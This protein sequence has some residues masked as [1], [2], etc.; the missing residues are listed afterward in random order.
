MK[1]A[2]FITC[3]C[4]ISLFQSPVFAKAPLTLGGFTLGRDIY[5]YKSSLN[6][7]SCREKR[8]QEYVGE[9]EI[10]P[11]PG[12]K[13]GLITYGLCDKVEK[14]IKIKLKIDNPSKKF[15]KKLL[16]K[17]ESTFGSP[18]EYKGDP[19]QTFIAWKWIFKDGR[20][21]KI[22]LILQHNLASTEEKIGNVIKLTLPSQLEREKACYIKKLPPK[23]PT[24]I[25]TLLKEKAMWDLYVPK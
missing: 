6:L 18:N 13:S 17:Y 12:F 19:F 23:Q 2:I 21:E 9:G 22:S 4:F 24:T 7:D 20:G 14:I 1:K 16:K 3:F 5:I 25:K 8:Y 11:I 10:N 15:F